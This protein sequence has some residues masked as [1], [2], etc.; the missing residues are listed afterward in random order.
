M[1]L[2]LI[3]LLIATSILF[4]FSANL[5]N[6]NILENQTKE[7]L[8]DEFL[9]A[10]VTSEI[11]Y[12][13]FLEAEVNRE[14][15]LYEFKTKSVTNQ[16]RVYDQFGMMHYILEVGST[17]VNLNKSLFTSGNY[18]LNFDTSNDRETFKMKIEVY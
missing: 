11:D 7:I 6:M 17:R 18:S 16:I 12:S 1:N 15:E 4:S 2:K 13:F 3:L 5:E 14:K 10:T 8:C 9:K